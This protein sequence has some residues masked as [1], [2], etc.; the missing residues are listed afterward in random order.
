VL[1]VQGRIDGCTGFLPFLSLPSFFFFFLISP[2]ENVS[3]PS[4]SAYN[5]SFKLRILQ[6]FPIDQSRKILSPELG[7][8]YLVLCHWS[9]LSLARCII[10]SS[11]IAFLLRLVVRQS[12]LAA[13]AQLLT[14]RW[15]IADCRP[16]PR[17]SGMLPDWSDLNPIVDSGS[18]V[19]VIGCFR[20]LEYL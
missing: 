13:T 1:G 20:L 12:C 11:P 5:N 8:S 19:R 18:P 17:L 9:F 4:G 10:L 14:L 15:K 16:D 2:S 3:S 6:P 7:M